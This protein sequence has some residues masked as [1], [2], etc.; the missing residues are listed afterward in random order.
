MR[1]T[2]LTL[3]AL[4][5]GIGEIAWAQAEPPAWVLM[6][7]VDI[8]P[9]MNDEFM[10]AQRELAALDKE[11][12]TAWRRVGRTAQFGD[13]YRF[14]IATPLERFAE[15]DRDPDDDPARARAISRVQRAITGRRSYAVRTLPSIDNPLPPE[16][17]PGLMIVQMVTVVPGREQDYLRVMTSDVLPHFDEAEMH[18]TTGA[19]TFGGEGGYIHLYYV[20]DFSALD[21]GSPAA[22]ALGAEGMQE[23]TSRMSDMLT[24]SEQWLVRYLPELS[25]GP[26]RETETDESADD[27]PPSD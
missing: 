25:Y 22:R 3:A 1:T 23:V 7:I 2:C 24:R 26:E 17:E 12:G 5:C 4:L 18:H 15:L 10:A 8:E 27:P 6:T 16:E 9:A 19:L 14:M 11:A 13:T 20:E 21:A